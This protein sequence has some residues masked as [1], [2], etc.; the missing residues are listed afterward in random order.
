MTFGTV[1]RKQRFLKGCSVSGALMVLVSVFRVFCKV[2][3]WLSNASN[4]THLPKSGRCTFKQ[5]DATELSARERWVLPVMRPFQKL[6]LLERRRVLLL[7]GQLSQLSV[8]NCNSAGSNTKVS[9][10]WVLYSPT[11]SPSTPATYSLIYSHMSQFKEKNSPKN[12][13]QANK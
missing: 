9:C 6:M 10:Y 7:K 12:P 8:R 5:V 1:K 13:N 2:A 11:P 3:C 4:H